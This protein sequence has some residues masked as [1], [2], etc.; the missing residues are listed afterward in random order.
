MYRRLAVTSLRLAEVGLGHAEHT[1][2]M[3]H[4]EVGNGPDFQTMMAL[5]AVSQP[6]TFGQRNRL[7]VGMTQQTPLTRLVDAA[8]PDPPARWSSLTLVERFLA[9]SGRTPALRDSLRREFVAWRAMAP[10]VHA[11][12][13]R[14]PLAGDG[15]PVADAL[16]RVGA[17]GMAALDR[18]TGAV[19]PTRAWQDSART[20]LDSSTGPQGLL[21]LV[22]VDPVRWLVE[23]APVK[24]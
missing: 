4:L 8:R 2:R 11:V 19:T 14:K 5:L 7:Q 9:D 22:V 15:V 12:A 16:A 17:V 3:L 10:A 6:V 1:A 18:L 13:V 23:V 21:R 24:Q 20:A